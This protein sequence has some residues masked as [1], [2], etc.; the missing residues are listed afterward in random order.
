MS[1][2]GSR[3]LAIQRSGRFLREHQRGRT[4]TPDP[5]CRGSKF[6]LALDTTSVRLHDAE[7]KCCGRRNRPPR[8]W[9][10]P[11]TLRYRLLGLWEQRGS[12]S[13]RA[14]GCEAGA[15]TR[16]IPDV[17][18][19][20]AAAAAP[21]HAARHAGSPAYPFEAIGAEQVQSIWNSLLDIWIISIL[22]TICVFSD[23]SSLLASQPYLA[24]TSLTSS[25]PEAAFPKRGRARHRDGR[26]ENTPRPAVPFAL[27]D[28]QES[29][30]I[31]HTKQIP[32]SPFCCNYF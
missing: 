23:D 32:E 16:S 11:P 3:V 30:A 4:S 10:A 7:P 6:H 25:L 29:N 1:L 26:A 31:G 15:D 17:G 12:G 9:P 2:E 19:S 5:S 18:T 21:E 22:E 24:R 14:G 28:R 13:G 8:L 27:T 20:Q